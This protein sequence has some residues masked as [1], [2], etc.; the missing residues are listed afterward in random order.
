MDYRSTRLKQLVLH[1]G[2]LKSVAAKHFEAS[3]AKVEGVAVSL[4]NTY[5][6]IN[7]R[8]HG[9][10]LLFS[11]LFGVVPGINRD[12]I[13]MCRK[14]FALNDAICYDQVQ[15]GFWLFDIIDEVFRQRSILMHQ[16]LFKVFDYID[17]NLDNEITLNVTANR[18]NLSSSY[19]SR[20]FNREMGVSFSSYVNIKKVHLAKQILISSDLSVNEIAYNVG[21]NEPNYF[22]KV[23]KRFMT[24]TPAQYRVSIRISGRIPSKNI[25]RGNEGRYIENLARIK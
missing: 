21:F 20:I 24:I 19:L 17:D 7:E 4:F 13:L 11:D 3:C 8:L 1:D 12:G 22:C 18:A 6:E 23:F 25:S 10:K 16:H 5:K 14:K 2:L 15:T 9:F